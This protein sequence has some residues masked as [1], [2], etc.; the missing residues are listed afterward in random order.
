[1][2]LGYRQLFVSIFFSLEKGIFYNSFLSDLPGA[3][4]G[5]VIMLNVST[6]GR[7]KSKSLPQ[8]TSVTVEPF[9][10]RSG[11]ASTV[12]A[13]KIP[14]VRVTTNGTLSAYMRIPPT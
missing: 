3:S 14:L 9:D 13:R 6:Y 12:G 11:S 10:W 5:A 1:M 4:K 2:L 7:I 8:T